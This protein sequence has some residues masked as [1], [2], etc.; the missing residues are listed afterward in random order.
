MAAEIRELGDREEVFI[1]TDLPAAELLDLSARLAGSPVTIFNAAATDDSL[2]AD[3]CRPNVIH[4]IPS[5]SQLTDAV[6]QY[7]VSKRWR[8]ILVLK[9]PIRTMRLPWSRFNARRND[10][11]R[12]SS[13]SSHSN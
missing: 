10:L 3:R 11:A 7:L 2:R 13:P 12:A 8:D 6:V 5:T 9:G 4:T 1:V